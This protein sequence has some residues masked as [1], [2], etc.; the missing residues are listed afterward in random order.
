M[1]ADKATMAWAIE[2]R[3]PLLDK[4]VIEYAFNIDPKF[5]N[6]KWILRKSVEDLLPYE[7]VWRKKQGFGTPLVDWLNGSLRSQVLDCLWNGE[8][9][10]EICNIKSLDKLALMLAQNKLKSDSVMALN[11]AN[12]IWSL[13][14]LQVWH[15]VWFGE[16]Y[17]A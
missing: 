4:N 2:E 11:P 12:V 1:K 8:L 13:F 3:L 6:D 7:I 5:K 17:E 15:D 9:L 16:K 10:R 14:A